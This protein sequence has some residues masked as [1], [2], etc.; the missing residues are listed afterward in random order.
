[1]DCKALQSRIHSRP[2]LGEGW[3]PFGEYFSYAERIAA[4][5]LTN[6]ERKLKLASATGNI[7]ERAVVVA[8][9]R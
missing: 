4:E 9:H 7:G 3:K 8:M 6:R 1:M 2:R 5:E